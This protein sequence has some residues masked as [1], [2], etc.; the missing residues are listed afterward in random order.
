MITMRKQLLIAVSSA[1]LLM[2]GAA[3]AEQSNVKKDDMNQETTGAATAPAVTDGTAAGTTATPTPGASET[4]DPAATAPADE[5][6]VT[7]SAEEM[8]KDKNAV[9]ESTEEMSTDK[10][11]EFRFGSYKDNPEAFSGQVAGGYSAEEL[12]GKNLVDAKGDKLGDIDDLLVTADN[13]VDKVLVSVGGFIGFGERRVALEID[14][15]SVTE[16]NVFTADISKDQLEAMP[17]YEQKES[18]WD[19]VAR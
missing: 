3:W 1:A 10:S 5:N 15:L 6:A 18:F 4:A 13:N 11:D 16:D 9:T 8:P 7:D 17:E 2:S 12:I 19:E 14:K